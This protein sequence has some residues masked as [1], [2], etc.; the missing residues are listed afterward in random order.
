MLQHL[1][2]MARY[3][4]WANERLYAAGGRVPAGEYHK[5]RQAFFGSMHATLS[6]LLVA[7]RLWLARIGDEP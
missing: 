7:D 1:R 6:H 3:N 5:A 2:R 4:R